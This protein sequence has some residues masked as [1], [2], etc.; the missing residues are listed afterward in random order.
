MSLSAFFDKLDSFDR[1]C[2]RNF[3]A[4]FCRNTFLSIL[5]HQNK[6][7]QTI[8]RSVDYESLELSKARNKNSVPIYGCVLELLEY[9]KT[10]LLIQSDSL[11]I[12]NPEL[13]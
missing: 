2:W 4:S 3:H 13:G 9:V 7:L 5:L 11:A 1:N 8:D 10:L 6:V 12:L